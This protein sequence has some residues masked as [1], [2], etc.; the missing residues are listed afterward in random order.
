M[1]NRALSLPEPGERSF[2]LWGLRQV[3]KTTLLQQQYPKRDHI[4]VDLTAGSSYRKYAENPE[5]LRYELEN[6]SPHKQ[7]VI[8][9]IQLVPALLNEI[10]WLIDNS[11]LKFALCGSNLLKLRGANLLGG[12]AGTF[13]L[14]GLTS[15]EF[16]DDFNLEAVLNKG[17]L[18]PAHGTPD[19]I[20]GYIGNYLYREISEVARTRDYQSFRTFLMEAAL[21]DGRTVSYANIAKASGGVSAY[22]VRGYFE[23]LEDSLHCRWLD[24]YRKEPKSG[25]SKSAK[26]YFT[27]VGLVNSLARRGSHISV[28]SS[29]FGKAFENW[30]CHELA[31]YLD[32][33]T[34][35]SRVKHLAYWKLGHEVDFI[36]GG[37][38][39][40]E[41]KSAERLE[42]KD[43]TGLRK[44][45]ERHPH[46]AERI[47]VCRQPYPSKTE[48]GILVLPYADFADRLWSGELIPL[49]ATGDFVDV[50]G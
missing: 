8:D 43:F 22:T 48:D 50:R 13:V 11:K 34:K 17:Y 4:W 36:V 26:F 39:A 10:Q 23:V 15:Q 32:Y 20:D 47:I 14:H 7:I 3:G 44:L 27:D 33:H 38:V 41:A 18:P 31:A 2:F 35:D 46:I 1:Y 45:A 12:R 49:A 6:A 19:F 16:G 40:I 5:A 25:E 28:G 30:V 9:E 24:P 37:R 21:R 42:R 29:D